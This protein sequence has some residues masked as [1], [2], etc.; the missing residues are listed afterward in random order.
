LRQLKPVKGCPEVIWSNR[1]PSWSAKIGVSLHCEPCISALSAPN[2]I[3]DIPLYGSNREAILSPLPKMSLIYVYSV[4]NT[5]VLMFPLITMFYLS[6]VHL[7]ELSSAVLKDFM[8][9]ESFTSISEHMFDSDPLNNH[10]I[11]LIKAIAEKYLQ[12]RYFYAGKQ[13][14]A[15]L[16]IHKQKISRHRNTKLILFS[17][18]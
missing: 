2:D 8:F 9:R 12:V 16:N 10:L 11:L 15:N 17:G 13:F 14:T 3:P 6:N 18:L 1:Q 5:F 4:R 7:H